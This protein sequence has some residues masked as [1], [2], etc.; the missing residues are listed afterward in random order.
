MK[1][2]EV[3]NNNYRE[4]LDP[5]SKKHKLEGVNIGNTALHEMKKLEIALN[6]KRDG[7]EI[8]LEPK[9]TSGFR[10]DV[11]VV[12]TNPP[13]AYEV[14][15]SESEESIAK[16]HAHYHGITVIPVRVVAKVDQLK[17]FEDYIIKKIDQLAKTQG[18]GL[19]SDRHWPDVLKTE[20]RTIRRCL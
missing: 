10:P 15:C 17:A 7:L 14:V 3:I 2:Q 8:L 6:C 13:I 11:L 4:F 12:D 5:M 19:F 9:L 16:K 1:R 20:V 18:T